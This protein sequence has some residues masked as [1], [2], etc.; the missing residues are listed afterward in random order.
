MSWRSPF[1]KPM[2]P[3][4]SD[5]QLSVTNISQKQSLNLFESLLVR[6]FR[7]G[8]ALLRLAGEEQSA[9]AK[10]DVARLLVLAEHKESLLDRLAGL[11]TAR[12]ALAA[13][14]AEAQADPQ[15][16]CHP[17]LS[18]TDS[19][20]AERL[21]HLFEGI[22]VITGQVR[23]LAHANRA[24]ASGA[25]ARAAMQQAGLLV[26]AQT[27]LPAL[28]AALL[29]A[30]DAMDAND[31]A[32]MQTAVGAMDRALQPAAVPGNSDEP[33]P[34]AADEASA[35]EAAAPQESGL[36]EA[37]ASLYRQEKAYRAVVQV[38]SRMIAGV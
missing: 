34:A 36:V 7:A 10:G 38:S 23:E 29:D 20:T 2:I 6:E 8:Q 19:E 33:A 13:G 17:A 3:Q 5:R 31:G 37:M 16:P 1:S 21:V 11:E 27:S 14:E 30:R 4:E 32:A 22:R 24:L 12:Q 18:Q 28:C 25:L 9:L 15:P 35:S 26:S